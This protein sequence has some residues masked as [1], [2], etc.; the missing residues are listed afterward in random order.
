MEVEWEE[1]KGDLS[2]S[3]SSILENFGVDY[4]VVVPEPAFK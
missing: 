1:R 3:I 4:L 2:E